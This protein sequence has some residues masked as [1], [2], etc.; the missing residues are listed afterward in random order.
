M[1]RDKTLIMKISILTIRNLTTTPIKLKRLECSRNSCEKSYSNIGINKI[2]YRRG[3]KFISCPQRQIQAKS[4]NL[5]EEVSFN[6]EPFESRTTNIKSHP[7]QIFRLTFEAE[8]QLYELVTSN[9]YARTTSLTCLSSDPRLHLTA[10][11]HAD[12][13]HISL[14]TSVN[15]ESWMSKLDDEI[16]LSYI[17]I[18]GT[19]NSPTCYTALPTV[20][21]QAV[22]VKEQLQNGVRFLDIRVQP[23]NPDDP[24][25][26][27]LI[28]V[29]SAFPISLTGNKYFRNIVDTVYN[30]LDANPSETVIISLKREGVG[31]STDQQ[32]SKILYNHYACDKG[33]WFTENRIPT[34]GEVRKKIVLIRR[35]GLDDSLKRENDHQ[36]WAIDAE[37]WP[38]NCTDGSCLGGDIRIQDFYEVSKVSSIQKKISYSVEQLVRSAQSVLDLNSVVK[39]IPKQPIFMNFL[40]GS[41]FWSAKCWPDRVAAK[42]NPYIIDHLCR[43]HNE[44]SALSRGRDIGNGSTGIVVCDWIGKNDNWDLVNCIIA[45]NTRLQVL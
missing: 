26:D 37:C 14:F 20:R 36:G 9:K 24:S 25:K 43:K 3:E 41:S 42:V 7:E 16:S 10:I 39:E 23:E 8:E 11:Y 30:F 31:R 35:F 29:H 18:P 15:L 12:F 19:H 13:R 22:G 32:L 40:S 2:F 17:S 4:D 27:E 34:L 5:I 44:P 28:L 33:R 6:V 21:C 1:R 38:D 45:M